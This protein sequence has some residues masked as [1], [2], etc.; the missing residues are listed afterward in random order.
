[1]LEKYYAKNLL[2]CYGDGKIL[3]FYFFFFSVWQFGVSRDLA[4]LFEGCVEVFL[5]LFFFPYIR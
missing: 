2:T 3:T 4:E 5:N 1:M